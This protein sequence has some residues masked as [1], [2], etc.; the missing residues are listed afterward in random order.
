VVIKP[1]I[2]M[3]TAKAANFFEISAFMMLSW[4]KLRLSLLQ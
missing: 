3:A 4:L 2:D 1:V